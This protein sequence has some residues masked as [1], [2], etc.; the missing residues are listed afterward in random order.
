[1][2][3]KDGTNYPTEKERG[4]HQ[5]HYRVH[6]NDKILIQKLLRDDKMSFQTFVDACCQA[7]MRGDPALLQVVQDW[8]DLNLLPEDVVKGGGVILSRRERMEIMRQLEEE[9]KRK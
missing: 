1:M 5:M 9:T 8:K 4:I 6:P 3:K 7:Y 2:K